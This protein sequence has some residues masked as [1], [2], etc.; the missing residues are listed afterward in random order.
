[1]WRLVANDICECKTQVQ[2]VLSYFPVLRNQ[3]KFGQIII[4]NCYET[5]E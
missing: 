3:N 2:F 1:M 4:W 5:E